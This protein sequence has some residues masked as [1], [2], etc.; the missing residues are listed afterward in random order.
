MSVYLGQDKIGIVD[1][2][3]SNMHVDKRSIMQDTVYTP[4]TRPTG[5]PDL[6]SLNLSMSGTNSFIYMTMRTGHVDDVLSCSWN[7]V[8][9]QSIT[10]EEGS[11]SNGTF[12]GTTLHT[13]TSNTTFT[14][15]FNSTNGYSDGFTV[16]KVSGRFS[17]FWLQDIT[18]N[19]VTI[20]YYAQ[21]VLERIWYVPEL[22]LFY[23]G[24]STSG[25]GNSTMTLQR[26]KVANNTGT[27]LTNLRY[28]WYYCYDLQSLDISGLYTPNV[29]NMESAF[30]Y[31]KIL[32]NINVSHFNTAKV[33]SMANM[34]VNCMRLKQLDLSTWNTSQLNYGGIASMFYGCRALQEILGLENFY[35]NNITSLSGLFNYCESLEDVSGIFNWN[36]SKVTNLSNVFNGCRKIKKL[37][38]SN[39]NVSNVTTIQSMFYNCTSVEHIIIPQ[40][41]TSTLTGSQTSVYYYCMALQEIDLSWIKPITSAVT[42]ISYFF[43]NCRSLTEIN[44]P[45]G[46]DVTGC[47]ASETFFRIFSYCHR[48]QR[49]TGIS[50]WDASNYNY[51]L[52]LM[53]VEDHAL[54][55]LDIKNWCPHPTTLYQMF[56]GCQSLQEIDLTGWHWENMTGTALASTFNNCNSL[57]AIKGIEHAGDSGNV[58]SCDSTF[59]SCTSLTSIPNISTWNMAKITTC[60]NMFNSCYSLKSLTISNWTLTK[61]TTITNMFRYCYSLQELE[62]TGWSL[63]ALT[64]NPDYI[65]NELWSLKKCSGLPI[66][67]NHR[68]QNDRSLP[69]DQWVRIFTQLPTV[70]SKTLYISS[71]NINR[72][73]ADTKA[74]A[75]GKGWTL[76]N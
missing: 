65:F 46:W 16:I 28:A 47:T 23:N 12:S 6:D 20:K 49:I 57:T 25:S 55:E 37:D 11:I 73:S 72:L 67:L 17:R 74:I 59:Q 3:K 53:F 22:T 24:S 14:K 50:N 45:E 19:G 76:A 69:E 52:N 36:I 54:M 13:G 10:I 75:T 71:E 26:D 63:P 48:L 32:E 51:S 29:T 56:S 30:S 64:T 21:P 35:T 68:Y 34:F 40:M 61:C 5:W 4:W 8:S 42:N 58:T 18:S 31:C 1:I 27:A 62:L 43:Y 60:T 41:Q 38:L 7:V 70:S 2:I 44:I 39:W 9:G 33:T 66:G 15:W